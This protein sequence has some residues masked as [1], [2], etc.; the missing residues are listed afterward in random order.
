VAAVPGGGL[1]GSGLELVEGHGDHQGGRDPGGAGQFPG[2]EESFGGVLERVVPA[3]PGGAGVRAAA[4]VRASAG[5]RFQDRFPQRVAGRGQMRADVAGAVGIAVQGDVAVSAVHPVRGQ[6]AVR[7]QKPQDPARHLPQLRGVHARRVL[8]QQ[9]LRGGLVFI[10][11]R[12]GQLPD[13]APDHA[14]V[15]R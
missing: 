6:G 11:D 15:R 8:G 3:L 5:E 2:S 9:C 12:G 10:A 14:R 13:Q 7:V 1:P 4:V